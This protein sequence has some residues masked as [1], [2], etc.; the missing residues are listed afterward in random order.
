[1]SFTAWKHKERNRQR[2]KNVFT[3]TSGGFVIAL[4]D[5]SFTDSKEHSLEHL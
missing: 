4:R 3:E 5:N 1:M 2:L